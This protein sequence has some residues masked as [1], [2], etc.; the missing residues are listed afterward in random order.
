[1]SKKTFIHAENNNKIL[2]SNEVKLY[3]PP[4]PEKMK[5]IIWGKELCNI[6]E[7]NDFLKCVEEKTR[8]NDQLKQQLAEKDKMHL[9][10]EKEF[11]NYCAYKWIE[12][13]IKGC[14]DREREY[15]Q[16]LVEKDEQINNLEQMCQICNKDQENEKL[17]Q[18]LEESFTEEDV[19]G[20]I[21]DRDK[22]IKFLQTELAEKDKEIKSLIVD[23]EKRISQ[24]QELMSNM[25]H[26]LTE[27]QNAI[28]EINKEFV[29]AIHDWKALCAE[30]DLEIESLKQQLEETNA[31]YD[32]TYE[33]SSEAIKELKQN[34]TH[35]AIQE[36]EKVRHL[37]VE[38]METPTDKLNCFYYIDQQIKELKGEK[39]A[40]D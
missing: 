33:Q 2:S 34:Q 23:Y 4:E 12:P 18:Q 35:L 27:K 9:L 24:E 13:E 26:L 38:K 21:E 8:E 37:L 5:I 17:K 29:Q 3:V 22:T 14:L 11:Q 15:K 28:D 31:G 19:N 16:Q 36:L 7:W 1:M 30:K 32:F 40:E 25:E 39:D 20:L 10:D 6:A